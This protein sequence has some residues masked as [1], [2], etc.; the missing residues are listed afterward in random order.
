MRVLTRAGEER[1][2]M[3]RITRYDEPERPAYVL[4]HALDVTEFVQARKALHASE[5][6]FRA[7]IEHS[8]EMIVILDAQ[9]TVA[10]RVR[11]PC[12]SWAP[13]RTVH[14]QKRL[15]LCSSRGPPADH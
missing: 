4:G 15:Y 5:Q 12:A 13:S 2:G 3:Y 10:M 7:L 14:W 1:I 9:G 8:Q 6:R 11:R